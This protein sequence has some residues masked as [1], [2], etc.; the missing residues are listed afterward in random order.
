MT[1]VTWSG[2]QAYV[3]EEPTDTIGTQ[4]Q[5]TVTARKRLLT[6]ENNRCQ[7]LHRIVVCWVVIQAQHA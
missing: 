3:T 5:T 4:L 2:P 7:A 6:R 1:T